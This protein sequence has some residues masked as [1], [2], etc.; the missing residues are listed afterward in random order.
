MRSP[1]EQQ[2]ALECLRLAQAQ[3][4]YADSIAG[5]GSVLSGGH[6]I[7]VAERFYAFVSGKDC[8]QAKL[9]AWYAAIR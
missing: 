6:I 5:H 9:D 8:A 1:E 2:I 3:A 7:D 4:G